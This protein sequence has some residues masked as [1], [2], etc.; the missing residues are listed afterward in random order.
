MTK[1]KLIRTNLR[2]GEKE[3]GITHVGQTIET[4]ALEHNPHR[5]RVVHIDDQD[6]LLERQQDRGPA[7][8]GED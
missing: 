6:I 2:H 8:L 3:F 1:D 4:H 5:Y 7:Y